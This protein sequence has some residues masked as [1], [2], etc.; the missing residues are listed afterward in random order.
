[1]NA[2]IKSNCVLLNSDLLLD[3][4]VDLLLLE[5]ALVDIILLKLHII[6]LQVGNVLND[7]FEN[8]VGGFSGVMLKSGALTSQELHFLLVV[9]QKFDGLF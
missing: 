1:M 8:I 3:E 6:L 9:V 5:I 7:F 2:S 4:S